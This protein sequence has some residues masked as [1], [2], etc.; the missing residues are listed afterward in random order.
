LLDERKAVAG[1][2][3]VQRVDQ[4]GVTQAGKPKGPVVDRYAYPEQEMEIEKGA[5]VRTTDGKDFAEVVAV[6]RLQR[7]IDIS[8]SRP[9]AEIHPPALFEFE[10]VNADGIKDALLRL[11][12]RVAT[13]GTLNA[14][15]PSAAIDLLL[16]NPPYLGRGSFAKDERELELD[17]AIRTGTALDHSVLAIQGP[18]GSGKTFTGSEMIVA[19]VKEG[20]KVGV[21]ANSHKV[22]KNLLETVVSKAAEKRVTV[23]VG[24]KNGDDGPSDGE[25]DPVKS[26]SANETALAALESGAIQVLGGTAWL[27]SRPEFADKVDVP[28]RRRSRADGAGECDRGFPGGQQHR[29]P[30]RSAAARPA[31]TR[32]ASGWRGCIGARASPGR[33]PDHS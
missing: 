2:K 6:D 31:A 14:A 22:I 11:G 4:G 7:T 30:R 23:N 32:L 12:E 25:A 29:A 26:F 10:Y 24:R 33:T 8:K 18:P 15:E 17:L 5:N 21:T 13:A 19:L 16:R 27:W 1:L 28:V 20:K 3:L 9:K